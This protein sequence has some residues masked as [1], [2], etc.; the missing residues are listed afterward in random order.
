MICSDCHASSCATRGFA[1]SG[2]ASMSL[3]GGGAYGNVT[4]GIEASHGASIGTAATDS[5][6]TDQYGSLQYGFQSSCNGGAGASAQ[7]GMI[8]AVR[9]TIVANASID[10]YGWNAGIAAQFL[11]SVGSMSPAQNTVGN[12]N[13]ISIYY[14]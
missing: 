1:A 3:F 13:G 11:S 8:L 14:G 2:G 10:M 6:A 9:A 5:S 4:N 12:L 7:S